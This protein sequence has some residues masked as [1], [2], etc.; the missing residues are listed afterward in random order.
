VR[1][2]R[3][4][5]LIFVATGVPFGLI[6]GLASVVFVGSQ[7]VLWP[8]IVAGAGFGGVMAGVLGSLDALSYRGAPPGAP[9]GPRQ[10]ATVLVRPGSDLSER[11]RAALA[12]LPAAVTVADDASGRYEATT[13]VSWKTWGE[14]VTVQ[15]SGDPAAPEACVTSRPRISTTLI[16]YGK[17]RSNVETVVRALRS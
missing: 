9:R 3:T 8:A 4:Y 5:A 12:S 6:V 16:D 10:S 17:G 15:L 11:V 7:A 14:R 1:W 2:L 13:R